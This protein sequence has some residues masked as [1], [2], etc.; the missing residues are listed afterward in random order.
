[1]THP[2]FLYPVAAMVLLTLIVMFAMLKERIG[3]MTER[4]IHP[5]S[6][7]SSSQLSAV[8]KNTKG[9]DNYKNL[10]ELPTLF[11]VL[12]VILMF[13]TKALSPVLLGLAWSYVALR[14]WHSFV[15]VG[16]NKVMT[17]FKIFLASAVVLGVMWVSAVLQFI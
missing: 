2:E 6:A 11:Y 13:N 14:A 7:P 4:R 15:H 8:L 17:R 16:Y 9:A 3:E 12:C 1:M 10:F 5:Q